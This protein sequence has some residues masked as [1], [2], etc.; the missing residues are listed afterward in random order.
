MKK[1]IVTASG[2]SNN[3]FGVFTTLLLCFMLSIN[4]SGQKIQMILNET[5]TNNSWQ[6]NTRESFVYDNNGYLT[7]DLTQMWDIPS[8]TWKN[9]SQSNYT[10]N[11]DGTVQQIV[12]QTW[13]AGLSLWD[14]ATRT[15][16]TYNA[17]KKV[18]TMTSELWLTAFWQNFSKNTYTYDVSGYLTNTLFQN[19]DLLS[20]SWKNF[21]QSN[22]SN[23]PDG[24]ASQVTIQLWDGV[25][26]WTNSQR[27]T[28]T[29]NTSKKVLTK[30]T[31]MWISGNWQNS[32]MET[33]SYDING[34][35]INEL[36]QSWD[37]LSSTWKN[38]SQNNYSNNPD[39]TTHQE[40]SQ[41]WDGVSAW[42]NNERMT[43]TYGTV[44]GYADLSEDSDLTIYPNPAHEI[45]TIHA[46]I[47]T[48]GLGYV[49]SDFS[50]R[51]I[52]SGRLNGETTT[53]NINQLANGVYYFHVG[54]RYK[55]TLIFIKK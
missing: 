8:T 16:F 48:P 27:Y 12:T 19:W 1:G 43:Y 28:Y 54:E 51:E 17:S 10:N 14:D 42:I 26:S 24:T 25:S 23:N 47:S 22:Y 37:Q 49:I 36:T 44:T 46:N 33:N 53:L 45:I 52:L 50:G 31:E 13:D 18:L 6:D 3:Y 34:Y 39:G 20:S 30:L 40:I 35:L 15:T 4:L 5:W 55:K 9:S 32:T 29:Y 21:N 38:Q 11:P 41:T 7:N 2:K